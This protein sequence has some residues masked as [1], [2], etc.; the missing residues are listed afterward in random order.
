MSSEEDVELLRRAFEAWNAGDLEGVI[1]MSHPDLEFIPL[2]SQLDGAAYSGAEGM[3]QFSRDA[4]EEWEYLRIL[5]DEFRTVGDE[6]V[7]LG[8]FDAKGRGSGVDIEFP[9]GWVARVRDGGLAY[10]R[11]Y[12]DPQEALRAVGLGAE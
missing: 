4:A 12:S 6:I 10:L 11:T 2:R 1:D 9:C 7:M 8:R 5:P 3:R